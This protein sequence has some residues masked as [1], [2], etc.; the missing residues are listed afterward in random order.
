MCRERDTVQADAGAKLQPISTANCVKTFVNCSK[1]KNKNKKIKKKSLSTHENLYDKCVRSQPH[2]QLQF[3]LKIMEMH[4][5]PELSSYFFYALLILK[6]LTEEYTYNLAHTVQ[7]NKKKI[8]SHLK[9]VQV[10]RS[11]HRQYEL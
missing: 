3:P 1:K 5:K 10:G 9:G 4:P 11:P 6:A 7:S 8:E 2:L